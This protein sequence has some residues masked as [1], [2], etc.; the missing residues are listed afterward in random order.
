MKVGLLE[1]DHV[2]KQL[3]H[4]G[5]DYQDMFRVLF[6]DLELVSYDLCK[7]HFPNSVQ[8]CDAY[9]VTGS[10]FSVYEDIDWINQLK[11]FVREI[12]QSQKYYIGICFGHQMLAEALGG[13]VEKSERGW[14]VGVHS[15]DIIE[16]EPWM[17]PFKKSLQLLMSCQDQVQQLPANSSILAKSSNCPIGMFTVGENMLGIQ[18]HPE[19][20]KAYS[21]ALME[22]RRDRIDSLVVEQGIKSLASNLDGRYFAN[23]IMQFLELTNKTF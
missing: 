19:F 8:E 23:W 20:P 16:Q 1:C 2:A 22:A 11:N 13:K 7:Q 3:Q 6:P 21:L 14:C 17:Q 15:F 9:L 10:K 18:A 4:I 5:G 12:H